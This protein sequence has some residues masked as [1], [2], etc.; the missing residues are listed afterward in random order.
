MESLPLLGWSF[1]CSAGAAVRAP[2]FRTCPRFGPRTSTS[3]PLTNKA[4]TPSK[5]ATKTLS[6][7]AIAKCDIVLPI[8]SHEPS[9]LTTQKKYKVKMSLMAMT[10]MNNAD[11]ATPI[12]RFKMPRFAETSA[13]GIMSWRMSRAPCEKGSKMGISRVTLWR[14]NDDIEATLPV[15]K[16]ADWRK[17]KKK[18]ATR[19]SASVSGR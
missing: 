14:L 3:T 2:P 12:R 9:S 19:A 5:A 7:L 8:S 4:D 11:G 6:R 16:K 1:S 15:E 18:R 10:T 13:N 17:T